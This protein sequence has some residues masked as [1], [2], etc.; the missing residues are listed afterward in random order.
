MNIVLLPLLTLLILVFAY[1]FVGRLIAATDTNP[2]Q[3]NTD[4][5]RAADSPLAAQLRDLGILGTPLLLAGAA[6]GLRFGWAPSFLWI[7]LAGT[8]IA[9]ATTIA[10][11][12]PLSSPTMDALNS[13][14]RLFVSAMLALLWADL[15]AHSPHALLGFLVLYWASEPLLS[16]VTTRRAELLGGLLLIIALAVFLAAFGLYWPLGLK[17]PV[18]LRIGPYERAAIAAPLVFYALTFLVLIQK[19]RQN[20]LRARPAYGAIGAL[21]LT[22]TMGLVFLAALIAHP[23]IPIPRLSTHGL[24]TALPL[25][26]SALPYGAALA[27]LGNNA[28]ASSS[29]RSLYVLILW[30]AALAIGFIVGLMSLFAGALPW[31][32]FFSSHPR[33]VPLLVAAVSGSTHILKLIGLGPWV[34]QLLLTGLLLTTAAALESQQKQLIGHPVPRLRLQP[35]MATALLGGL[36]WFGHGLALADQIDMGALLGIGAAAALILHRHTLP[37]F[38]VSFALVLLVLTDITLIVTGGATPSTHPVRAGLSGAVIIT[39]AVVAAR[40]WRTRSRPVD[41][42]ARRPGN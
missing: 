34:G 2:A 7:L 42:A 22:A 35:L 18:L 25:L 24:W 38:V 27:P 1:R 26:A 29:A 3:Y 40:L 12:R 21:L 14:G 11:N 16:L 23:S 9:A 19:K 39:E 31:H 15:A 20:K 28:L 13:G 4:H 41:H 33:A 36:L 32:L 37:R 8:T 30:Q 5:G 6:F 17:G 10:R